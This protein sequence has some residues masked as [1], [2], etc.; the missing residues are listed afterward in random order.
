MPPC[1]LRPASVEVTATGGT[2]T[3]V[4][5]V[6]FYNATIDRYIVTADQEIVDLDT[7][8]H[9]GWVRTGEAFAV[10]LPGRSDFRGWPVCRFYGLPEAHLD[11][12]FLSGRFAECNALRSDPQL[13]G[14]WVEDRA[15]AFE[16]PLPDTLS[17]ACPF[18]SEPVYR[19]WN[20]RTGDHRYVV[21]PLL[22]AQLLQAGW[23]AEGDGPSAVALCTARTPLS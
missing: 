6:E 1:V 16:L 14:A 13:G 7:G 2:V 3:A 9:P 19:F 21:A 20:P 22:R 12:H 10:Y 18:G 23:I 11:S 8:V 4:L 17:G 15:N 5:A